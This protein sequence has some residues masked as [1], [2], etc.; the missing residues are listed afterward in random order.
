MEPAR[1]TDQDLGTTLLSIGKL[2]DGL[3]RNDV[4]KG[5]LDDHFVRVSS[6]L[7]DLVR[8]L[9]IAAP[10]APTA[11]DAVAR[12]PLARIDALGAV[13]WK[14]LGTGAYTPEVRAAVEPTVIAAMAELS[15]AGR[16]LVT[17]GFGPTT[18]TGAVT[19]LA[20]GH[21]GVPKQAEASVEIDASGVVGDRQAERRHHGRPWQALCLWSADIIDALVA[22]GHPIRPGAAGENITVSGLDWPSVRPGVRLRLG[23]DVICEISSFSTPCQKNA[24]WFSDGD[25]RRIDESRGPLSR[26]YASVLASGTL[27]VGDAVTLLP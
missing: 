24:Q 11:D 8:A 17:L 9:G 19:H 25:F 15:A 5:H 1:Y 20:R 6:M 7:D 4:P 22:Q 27:H 21:G 14:H 26:M 18:A 13:L 23:P 10:T 3:E 12:A 16:T 2:L